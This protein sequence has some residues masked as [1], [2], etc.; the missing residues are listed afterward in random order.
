MAEV[1]IFCVL[2]R[3][4]AMVFSSLQKTPFL[5]WHMKPCWKVAIV[6]TAEG[7]DGVAFLV[8]YSSIIT[9]LSFSHENIY[10]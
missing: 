8:I 1:N 3:T 5:V 4:G 2:P 6:V 10:A 9:L 7:G